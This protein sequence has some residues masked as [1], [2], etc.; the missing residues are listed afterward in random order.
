VKK[1]LGKYSKALLEK[2]EYVFLSKSDAV[3]PDILKKRM[4]ALKK[5][6]LSPIAISI[7]DWDSIEGVKKILNG[8]IK[9]KLSQT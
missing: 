6:K 3:S 7:Y 1:E 2:K 5:I 8:I 4:L 9:D